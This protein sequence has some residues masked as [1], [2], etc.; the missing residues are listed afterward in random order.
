M[1]VRGYQ[2][3]TASMVVDLPAD[4]SVPPRVWASLGTPCTGVFL[5]VGLTAEAGAPPSAVV[6]SVLGDTTAWHA[7]A[8]LGRRVEAP[9]DAGRC[10]LEEVRAA[11]DPVEDD[12]WA[13][14]A[15]LWATSASPTRWRDA[16]GRWDA[17]ARSALDELRRCGW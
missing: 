9:G 3:T 15:E 12:A 5:P 13:E 11:L 4:A 7:F 16:A 17:A 2:C 14:A 8:E 6:P 1:H 10:A